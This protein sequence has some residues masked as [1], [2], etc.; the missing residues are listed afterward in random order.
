MHAPTRPNLIDTDLP[1]V[2]TDEHRAWLRAM[3]EFCEDVVRPGAAERSIGHRHDAGLAAALGGDGMGGDL[4][5]MCIAIEEVARVDSSAAVTVHVQVVN[6]T[7]VAALGN[8]EQ[9]RSQLPGV[10]SGETF[11]AFG[12]TEPSGGSDAANLS[13]RATLRGASGSST[14]PSSPSP[15]RARRPAAT[16]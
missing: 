15:T 6:S 2:L 9:K 7:L 12:L 10:A 3:R 13:T 14:V 4:A 1:W 8:E 16:C 11:I 5:S